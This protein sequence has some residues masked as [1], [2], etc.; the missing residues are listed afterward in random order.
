MTEYHDGGV[1]S[2]LF[3]LRKGQWKFNYYPGHSPQLFDLSVDPQEDNNLASNSNFEHIL[4][5]CEMALRNICDPDAVDTLVH[6]KQAAIIEELGGYD[7]VASMDEADIFIEL[8]ALYVN[9][10]DLRKPPDRIVNDL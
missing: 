6:E 5:E 9:S 2:G 10:E 4:S 3:A 8:G 7:A 1:S